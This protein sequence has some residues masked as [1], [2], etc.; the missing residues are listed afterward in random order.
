MILSIY[1]KI[2][3]VCFI[4]N[5]KKEKKAIKPPSPHL[6]PIYKKQL[7]VIVNPQLQRLETVLH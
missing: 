7:V 5:N 6:Y 1:G 2:F 4:L 3:K